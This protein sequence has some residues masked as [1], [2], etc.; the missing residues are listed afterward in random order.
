MHTVHAAGKK[1]ADDL[2]YFKKSTAG[3]GDWDYGM[4]PVRRQ[5]FQLSKLLVKI[6]INLLLLYRPL[7]L[8]KWS[9]LPH[10]PI[11]PFNG[12]LCIFDSPLP[13]EGKPPGLVVLSIFRCEHWN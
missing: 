6:V 11:H 2:S 5:K 13:N 9:F 1:C 10:A 8:V 3:R 12:V 7:Q 4:V